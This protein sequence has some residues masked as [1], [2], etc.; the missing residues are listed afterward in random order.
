MG[1]ACLLA[2]IWGA[3]VRLGWILPEEGAGPIV[4]HGQLMVCGFLGTLISLER[5]VAL[6]RAWA[7]GAP[8]LSGVGALA[9]AAGYDWESVAPITAAGALV[10]VAASA[11]VVKRQPAAF[12]VTMAI[13]AASWLAGSLVWATGGVGL[14]LVPWW[15]S[16]L[17]LTIAGE[18]LELSRFRPPSVWGRCSFMVA[19]ALLA[20]GTALTLI[21][22]GMGLRVA[23]GGMLSLSLWLFR[24]D[25]ARHTVRQSGLPRFTAVCLLSGY[26]WLGVAGCLALVYGAVPPKLAYDAFL[27]SVFVGFVFSMIFGHAPI[28]LPAVLGVSVPYRPV[29]YL[30]LALL[31][32][33]I[34]LRVG[35][36]LAGWEAARPWGGLLNA[37]AVLAFL[38]ATVASGLTARG[39]AN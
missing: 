19:A 38:T 13:G 35:V 3:L 10:F 11:V 18:R 33:S 9:I 12:T 16:F 26:V 14:E 6:G 28:I 30:H 37:V 20:C 39:R 24:Y 36:D 1:M 31:H 5:A 2:G 22:L 32:L 21:D 27:H 23:G 34:A 8:L 15:M 25:I 29:F 4:F 17:I 7:Y